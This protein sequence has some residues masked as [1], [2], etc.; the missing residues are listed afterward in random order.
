MELYDWQK[1]ILETEGDITI[2]GGRQIGKS[3]IV[4]ELIIKRAK[5]YPNSRTLITSPSERQ[6]NYLLEKVKRVLGERY[7]YKKRPTQKELHLA[8]GSIIYKFPIGRTGIFVEGLS[9]ID[10]LYVDE[11][12]HMAERPWDAI[13]PMLAEPKKR[14][15]GWIT[16]LSNTR[17]RPFG[18]FRDSFKEDSKYTKFSISAEDCPHISK[19]FLEAEKIRLGDSR[20]RMI[21]CGEFVETDFKFFPSNLISKSMTLQSWTIR[22][23]YNQNRKY[24]IG[25]D[26]ARFGKD[27]AGIVMGELT[28]EGIKII[29]KELI[30]KCSMVEL[31]NRIII[32]DRQFKFNMI[33]IDGMGVGGGFVDIMQELF[34]GRVRELNNSAKSE[35]IGKIFKEDLYANVLRLME[36]GRI[37]IIR[38]EE[39]KTSLESVEYD[40]EEF[41]GENTDLA[42]AL[43]RC[44]WGVKEKRYEPK[45]I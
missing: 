36:L 9:S 23:N 15:L 16:L 44:C 35:G 39:I 10:F 40:G 25:I 38:D 37:E 21:W 30:P 13:L 18:V 43:I 29:H 11:A 8:N 7:K 4:A 28:N 34:K 22:E 12:I 32:W 42:E 20:Y 26:P 1:K 17:G 3:E 19:E 6:E 31:R 41:L 33:Y 45:M 2:K 14:G 24:V 5:K 27:K